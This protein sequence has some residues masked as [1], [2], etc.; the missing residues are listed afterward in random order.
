MGYECI[1]RCYG[2]QFASSSPP[3]DCNSTMILLA[4]GSLFSLNKPRVSGGDAQVELLEANDPRHVADDTIS[5]ATRPIFDIRKISE[6]M[7]HISSHDTHKVVNS[8]GG[9]V[10]I[11]RDSPGYK[12][13]AYGDQPNIQFGN[14]NNLNLKF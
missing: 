7:W 11:D 3:V 10:N 14:G 8:R 5:T 12:V 13:V 4:D 2:Q 6:G 1:I 9:V